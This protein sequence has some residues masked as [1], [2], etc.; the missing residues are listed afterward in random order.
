MSESEY[1]EEDA[2]APRSGTPNDR[3]IPHDA[4]RRAK[5][6]RESGPFVLLK[7]ED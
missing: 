4:P 3:L 5:K 6:A 7:T 2:E 1:R